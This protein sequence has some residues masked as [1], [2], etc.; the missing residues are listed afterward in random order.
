M[1]KAIQVSVKRLVTRQTSNYFP[2]LEQCSCQL[3]ALLNVAQPR[4]MGLRIYHL[5]A[6]KLFAYRT[7]RF[8]KLA[9]SKK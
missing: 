2:N 3:E 7:K 1:I 8:S 9:K 6:L 5:I 4:S